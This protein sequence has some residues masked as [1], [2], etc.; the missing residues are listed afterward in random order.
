MHICLLPPEILLHIFAIYQEDYG[1]LSSRATLA[2]LARTCKIFKEPALDILWKDIDGLEPLISCLVACLPK[3]ISDKNTRGTLTIKRPLLNREW[4]LI[5]RYTQRIHSLRVFATQLDTIDNRVVQALIS[6]PSPLLPNLHDLS[7]RDDRECFIPL[8]RTLLSPTITLL[9][10]DSSFSSLPSFAKAALLASLGARCP[11]IRELECF[12]D[13]VDSE[14]ITDAICEALCGLKE[15]LRLETD[16]FNTRILPHLA[17]LPSLEYLHFVLSVY[18]ADEPQPNCVSTF[19]SHFDQVRFTIP[20]PFV[21][22]QCLNNVHF[23]SCR[24]VTVGVDYD[25]TPYNPLDATDLISSFSKCFSPALEKIHFEFEFPF[26]SIVEEDILADPIFALHF[27]A[28]APLLSFSHLT[29][30]DLDWICASAVD[31]A[32]LKTMA[33]SWPHLENFSFGSSARWLVPPSLTF[34]GF[35]HLIH[36]CRHLHS[37]ALPFC[38]CPVDANSEPFS[39]TIPNEKITTLFVGVSPIVDPI[40]VACQLHTLLPKLTSVEFLDFDAEFFVPPPFEHFEGE[41]RRVNDFLK[42]LF[43]VAKMKRNTGQAPLAH[44]ADLTDPGHNAH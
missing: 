27:D 18:D 31:D 30:L 14:E 39:E 23:L 26:S 15:L 24:S 6:A 17:F 11:C 38:A 22:S 25:D 37:I 7:W 41:W 29:D 16:V 33:Q 10:L 43:T 20:T 8:L 3:G 40:S 9:K 5:N 19:S 13:G 35:V 12:Y 21:L 42:V 4:S 32:S 36:H 28:I 34:V 44:V 1:P 2:S